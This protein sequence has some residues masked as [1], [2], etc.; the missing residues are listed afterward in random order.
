[1]VAGKSA[2]SATKTES[3]SAPASKKMNKSFENIE[4]KGFSLTRVCI[5]G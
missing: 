4:T 1:M 5:S 2:V 3:Q